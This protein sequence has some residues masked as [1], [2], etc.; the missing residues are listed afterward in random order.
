MCT[1][2]LP[3][4]DE[5]QDMVLIGRGKWNQR[6]KQFRQEVESMHVE[7]ASAAWTLAEELREEYRA[8]GNCL[9]AVTEGVLLQHLRSCAIVV[10]AFQR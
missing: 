1:V 5:R 3:L 2:L 10:Q 7:H 6:P 8:V 4:L 9:G